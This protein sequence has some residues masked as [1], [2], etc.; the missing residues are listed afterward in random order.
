M[1]SLKQDFQAYEK[2]RASGRFKSMI[3]QSPRIAAGLSVDTYLYILNHHPALCAIWPD[4][5]D[6]RG[7]APH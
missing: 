7:E 6:L 1:S 2:V 4:A 3:G 5:A